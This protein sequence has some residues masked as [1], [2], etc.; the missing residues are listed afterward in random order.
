MRMLTALRAGI[1]TKTAEA[2]ETVAAQLAAELPEDCVL[3]L[4]GDLGAGK[5]TFVKGLARAWGIRETITSPTFNLFNIYQG[6]RQLVHLDAYRLE[7]GAQADALLIDE[8][9]QSP[10]CLAIEWPEKFAASWLKEA[11]V[12]QLKILGDKQHALQLLHKND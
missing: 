3:A 4:E 6:T 12:L 11:F 1:T 2:T 10:F 5:T 7:S 8:F 9:L